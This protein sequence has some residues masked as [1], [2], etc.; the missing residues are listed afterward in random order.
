M[1]TDCIKYKEQS[2]RYIVDYY[3]TK[4]FNY[5]FSLK[6]TASNDEKK[7]TWDYSQPRIARIKR[8]F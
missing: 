4:A 1:H 2:T 5:L 3:V 8:I 7:I 6:I